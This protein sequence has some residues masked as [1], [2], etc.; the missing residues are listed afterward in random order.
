MG[1][2]NRPTPITVL[3]LRGSYTTAGDG[4]PA[5]LL[6]SP[7][8][9]ARTYRPT[10]AAL[11]RT[12]RVYAVEMPGSGSSDRVPPRWGLDEYT[13]WAAGFLDALDL[14]DATVIGHSYS[15]AVPILV[16]ARHPAR[17]GRI[18]IVDAIGAT[19]AQSPAGLFFGGVY[20]V[21]LEFRLVVRAWHH[22][23]RNLVLRPRHFA[24]MVRECLT[25]DVT[26]DAARVRVP[27]L[28]AWGAED[29]TL[30]PRAAA[31]FVGSLPRPTVHV[32]LD[33]SHAWLIR[34]PDEFAAAV[35]A[36]AAPAG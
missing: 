24:S 10:V 26:A 3:G 18:V 32:C 17:V 33:H 19:G 14:T 4:P 30:P 15:G 34:R 35:A 8:A 36:F 23:A 25:A 13:R 5:V 9:L 7:L 31:V 21:A 29:H 28:V 11:A 22:V 16:A 27:A 12:F 20:D 2:P 6:A 1:R